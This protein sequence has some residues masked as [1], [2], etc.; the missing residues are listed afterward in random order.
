MQIMAKS[1]PDRQSK[2]IPAGGEFA[3][4][5]RPEGDLSLAAPGRTAFGGYELRGFRTAGHGMEG[6]IWS[7]NIYKDG[8]K[9]MTVTDQGDGGQLRWADT[10][11]FNI[12]RSETMNTLRQV[13]D[14]LHPDFV[15]DYST[16]AEIFAETLVFSAE[17]DKFQRK[18][19]VDRMTAVD[20][21]ITAGVITES[22][23]ELFADPGAIL[24]RG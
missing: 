15:D 2:G 21:H 1:N 24:S 6:R 3:A 16:S 8:K 22:D 5:Q 18:Y 4:Q 13:A 12:E 10:V 20:D 17:L 11:G 19:N 23:R 7:A 14:K 9:A